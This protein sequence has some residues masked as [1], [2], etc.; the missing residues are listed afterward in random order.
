MSVQELKAG[1]LALPQRERH[2][3]VAWAS[4]L[5]TEYGDIPGE[6][7]DQLAAQVWD[8][9]DRYAPPTHPAR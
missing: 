4:R 3:F 6:A 9:D 7:L 8:E 1:V 2:Q 5:E